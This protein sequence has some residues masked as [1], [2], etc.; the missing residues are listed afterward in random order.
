MFIRLQN[1]WARISKKCKKPQMLLCCAGL[2]RSIIENL[3]CMGGCKPPMRLFA[4]IDL[5]SV[6][7]FGVIFLS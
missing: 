7:L 4:Q 5:R 3:I 1:I 6:M 2:L